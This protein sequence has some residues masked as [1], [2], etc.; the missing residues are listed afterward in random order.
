MGRLGEA[1]GRLGEGLLGNASGR[2]GETW[3]GLFY[4]CSA[5]LGKLGRLGEAWGMLGEC[6]GEA[7]GIYKEKHWKMRAKLPL[8][9]FC[10]DVNPRPRPRTCPRPKKNI[11]K[12]WQNYHF[13]GSV[14]LSTRAPARARA[15]AP[16]EASENT[17]KCGQDYHYH[18]SVHSDVNPRP[19]PRTCPRPS[20]SE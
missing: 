7:W 10:S 17:R 16:G 3:G 4:T 18:G 6:F 8:P 9:W 5:S 1:W 20:V 2:L 19:R 15:R 13:H 11:G 12:C 14:V